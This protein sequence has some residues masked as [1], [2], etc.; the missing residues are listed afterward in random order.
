MSSAAG[1]R[2]LR[3]GTKRKR[4]SRPQHLTRSPAPPDN[5][6]IQGFKRSDTAQFSRRVTSRSDLG[7]EDAELQGRVGPEVLKMLSI[8]RIVRAT[9]PHQPSD[10]DGRSASTQ[11]PTFHAHSGHPPESRGHNALSLL[12]YPERNLAEREGFEPSIPLRVCRISSA[13]LSTTQPP[14]HKAIVLR[15]A[16]L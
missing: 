9:E 10:G 11:V 14:L 6:R 16:G 15:K 2:D 1:C 5:F 8:E 3:T 13:V 12:P 4:T 7:Q